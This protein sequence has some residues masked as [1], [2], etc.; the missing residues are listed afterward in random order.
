MTRRARTNE[1][2]RTVTHDQGITME[3]THGPML[4][5]NLLPM[6]WLAVFFFS[7]GLG[8]AGTI[9]ITSDADS[10]VGTLRAALAMAVDG[11]VIN[12]GITGAINLSGGELLI[13]RSMTIAG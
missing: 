3:A 1:S 5:H 9:I 13:A 11:D 7:S 8:K 2:S 12:F 6:C 4:L 10:G